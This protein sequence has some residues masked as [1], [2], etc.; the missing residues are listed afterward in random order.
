MK[1]EDQAREILSSL[2][3]DRVDKFLGDFNQ[4]YAG[5]SDE[6][7]PLIHKKYIPHSKNKDAVI[8]NSRNAL[9][10]LKTIIKHDIYKDRLAE[11]AGAMAAIDETLRWNDR[12]KPKGRPPQLHLGERYILLHMK[13]V[14][15]LAHSDH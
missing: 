13:E 6:E 7:S 2:P 8:K 5:W 4:N 14:H 3:K 11:L 1:F 12:H 10:A 9:D 15:I